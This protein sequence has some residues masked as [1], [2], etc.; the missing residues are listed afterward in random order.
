[1]TRVKITLM[2][3]FNTTFT[4]SF[5]VSSDVVSPDDALILAVVSAIETMCAAVALKI[6]L[7]KLE[8]STATAGTGVLVAEDKLQ[9]TVSDDDDNRHTYRIPA[10]MITGAGNPF[11]TDNLTFKKT[12]TTGAAL[13]AAIETYAQSESGSNLSAIIE[14]HRTEGKHLK[15]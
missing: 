8:K 6:E 1:M 12:S 13:S 2:G 10:P 4:M 14:G 3:P 9:V 11:D 7:S 15:N 5:Y